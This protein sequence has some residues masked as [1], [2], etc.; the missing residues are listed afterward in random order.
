VKNLRRKAGEDHWRP[1]R[2]A[3]FASITWSRFNGSASLPRRPLSLRPDTQKPKPV[4]S[5]QDA[6]RLGSGH[7]RVKAGICVVQTGDSFLRL[8]PDS[9][10]VPTRSSPL[11]RVRLIAVSICGEEPGGPAWSRVADITS[12]PIHRTL[13]IFDRTPSSAP[14]GFYRLV[15][16]RI[17]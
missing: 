2:A 4:G 5:P 17:P 6:R 3:P 11:S 13:R 7:W 12:A 14:P 16:P 15:S 10:T 1:L 9:Y 8:L